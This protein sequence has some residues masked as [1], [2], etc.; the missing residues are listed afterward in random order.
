[1]PSSSTNR[2]NKKRN[3][4]QKSFLKKSIFFFKMGWMPQKLMTKAP[5][6][7]NST[8]NH[9]QGGVFCQNINYKEKDKEKLLYQSS[10]YCCCCCC[11]ND[12]PSLDTYKCAVHELSLLV[13]FPTVCWYY[14][15]LNGSNVLHSILYREGIYMELY[16]LFASF[17]LVFFFTL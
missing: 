3:H 13:V 12:D 10:T 17:P 15:K 1:M 6:I 4:T 2:F 16:F 7:H 11:M 14:D 8:L 9:Y 5:I